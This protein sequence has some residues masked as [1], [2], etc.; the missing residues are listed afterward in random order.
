MSDQR[1]ISKSVQRSIFNLFSI[2]DVYI[3]TKGTLS[4]RNEK[5]RTSLS[6]F[7]VQMDFVGAFAYFALDIN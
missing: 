7:A 4:K 1:G 2:F 6:A 5:Q 3:T